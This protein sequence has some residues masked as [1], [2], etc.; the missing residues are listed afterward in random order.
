MCS[1]I[2]CDEKSENFGKNFWH[3]TGAP[4]DVLRK[5]LAKTQAESRNKTAGGRTLQSGCL[6][7]EK[8]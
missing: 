3:L 7:G 1:K 6:V 8:V 2:R 4:G 5:L